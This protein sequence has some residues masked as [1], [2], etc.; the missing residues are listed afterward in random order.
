M[1][2]LHIRLRY[3]RAESE[4]RF[5]SLNP[6]QTNC[7]LEKAV[8]KISERP[9]DYGISHRK[10]RRRRH[11]K[12]GDGIP[13]VGPS[14]VPCSGLSN[15]SVFSQP[16]RSKNALSDNLNETWVARCVSSDCRAA[17]AR[18]ATAATLHCLCGTG[19]HDGLSIGRGT[20]CTARG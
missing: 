18:Q 15:P 4:P 14:G 6:F 1:P 13:T 3:M 8:R 17:P 10:E 7:S 5:S 12:P 9:A 11:A 19:K 2:N 16:R 20:L